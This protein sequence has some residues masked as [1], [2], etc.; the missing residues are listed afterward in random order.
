[1][2]IHIEYD[3]G[4]IERLTAMGFAKAVT[5]YWFDGEKVKDDALISEFKEM[6]EYLRVYS[7]YLQ[8]RDWC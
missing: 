8:S 2:K 4:I 7:K 6:V 3:N 1:M 5:E